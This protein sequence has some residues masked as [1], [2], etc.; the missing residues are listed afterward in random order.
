MS[1]GKRLCLV[2][3]QFFLDFRASVHYG[4]HLGFMGHNDVITPV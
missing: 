4:G 2:V 3:R 1:W